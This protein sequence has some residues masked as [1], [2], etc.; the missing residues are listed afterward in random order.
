MF[1][2]QGYNCTSMRRYFTFMLMK[3]NI[4][5]SANEN[6][7]LCIHFKAIMVQTACLTVR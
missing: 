1:V 7:Y 5:Y 3:G 4:I 6:S 2:D